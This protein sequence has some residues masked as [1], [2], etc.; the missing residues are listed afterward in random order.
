MRNRPRFRLMHVDCEQ[1]GL[2]GYTDI[3]REWAGIRE[4]VEAE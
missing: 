1:I 2:D 4:V 3:W